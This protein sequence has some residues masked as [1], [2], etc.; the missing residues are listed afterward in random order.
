MSIPR[1]SLL[2][3]A[4]LGAGSSILSA[5][6]G[7]DDDAFGGLDIVERARITPELSVLV[8]AI[9]AADLGATL[10]GTGPFTV[11]APT[12]SAFTALLAELGLTKEQLLADTA[13]LTSVLT[14]HVLPSRVSS[15]AVTGLLGQ[16]ITTVNGGYFKIENASGLKITDGRNRV[17][18]ITSPDITASNGTIHLIDRVLLPA[19]KTVVET[20]Q[21][22]PDFSILVDALVAANLVT[23]L[24]AT[25]PFTV[26]APTNAAFAAALTELGVTQD[27]LLADTAFLTEVLTYHVV[28]GL[29]LRAQ[30]PIGTAITTVQGSSFTVGAD[31]A[32]TDQR[33]RSS[34]I[35]ATDV[36][37]SNGVIHVI[38]KVILPPTT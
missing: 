20:A 16:P 17:T 13:L 33:A 38:D 28:P 3:A 14:Y 11:F 10:K 4:A 21:A 15:Q 29:V 1:R 30:V 26:F 6:G 35:T 23:T 22:L 37:A 7:G 18:A 25:G 19:D 32:I 31:L 24:S 12:N 9:T 34:Q 8:E 27:Q 5:C 2:L 36:L